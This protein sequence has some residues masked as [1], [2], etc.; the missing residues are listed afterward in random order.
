MANECYYC[1]KITG[2]LENV[3]EFVDFI[4]WEGKYKNNGVGRVF[5]A[6]VINYD[7]YNNDVCSCT[8]DGDC[9][10]S[11]YTSMI[12]NERRDNLCTMSNKLNVIVEVFSQEPGCAF[13]EHYV[14]IK[15]DLDVD[16][17]VDW[18]YHDVSTYDSLENYNN[19]C[20][21]SFT[22]DMIGENGD[23]EVG[24][25]G[26]NFCVFKNFANKFD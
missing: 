10:W 2:K 19:E 17:C 6:C 7:K 9:A 23:I 12:D 8:I 13:Q 3:R 21:T 16:E 4:G 26:D 14:I 24:G 11:V 1:M 25:F 20:G 22:E 18:Q 15:G 5:G